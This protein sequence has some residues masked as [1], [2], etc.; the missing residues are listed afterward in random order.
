MREEL[1][2]WQV[3]KADSLTEVKHSKLDLEARIEKW[4]SAD[5]SPLG[6][7]DVSNNGRPRFTFGVGQGL[8]FAV[9]RNRRYYREV[10]AQGIDLPEQKARDA[11]P[12]PDL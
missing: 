1:R 2:I 8:H 10:W 9:R 6:V 4:I 3:D 11:T 12:A 5:I 7:P